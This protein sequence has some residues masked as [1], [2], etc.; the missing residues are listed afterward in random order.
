MKRGIAASTTLATRA[1][2]GVRA[3]VAACVCGLSLFPACRA[4]A[5]TARPAELAALP[6]AISAPVAAAAGFALRV[7]GR[8]KDAIAAWRACAVLAE[9]ADELPLRLRCLGDAGL[10]ASF[11]GQHALAAALQRE[12]LDLAR[13]H[14]PAEE[15]G[16][17]LTLAMLARRA[18]DL[19]AAEVG[20]R[21]VV[22]LAARHHDALAQAQALSGL[23]VVRKNLGDY[24]EA[25][26]AETASLALRLSVGPNAKLHISYINLA[27][28]YEQLE[29]LDRARDYQARAL[30][31]STDSP[32]PLDRAGAQVSMA[33]LLNDSGAVYA[34]T[35]YALA[36][37]AYEQHRRLGNRPGMLDARFHRGRAQ[38]LMGHLD[39]AQA[40]LEPLLAEAEALGQRASK[41]HVLFRLAEV[42]Q[43]RGDERLALDLA[44]RALA[45]YVEVDNPH[46]QAKTHALLQSIYA[47]QGDTVEA[48]QHEVARL[49]LRERLLGVN[50]MRR[51]GALFDATR[52]HADSDRIRLLERDNQMVEALNE[53][54]AYQRGIWALVAL[55]LGLVLVLVAWRY[56]LSVVRNHLFAEREETGERERARL[57]EAN[58]QLYTSATT[59]PLTGLANRSHGLEWLRRAIGSAGD[60]GTVAI[61]LV[62]VDHFKRINDT[63]GHLAGD[64][65]LCEVA[66]TLVR[67]L[68]D[69]VVVARF[70][71]EEFL[72][73]FDGEPACDVARRLERARA[74]MAAIGDASGVEVTVSIG[75]CVRRG[76]AAPVDV[77]LAAADAA[78]YRAKAM[79]RNRV[80]GHARPVAP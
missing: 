62:D 50:A 17:S 45:T 37:D 27:A 33:G 14:V 47:A 40:E 3:V 28:L 21:G 22:R 18:G 49:R 42:A 75:W 16:A 44:Q 65:V 73:V 25:L 64:A 36:Q 35:A 79:G 58:A 8:P 51:V 72:A 24:Y 34:P 13:D 30:A 55:S 12:R 5:A 43:A 67:T 41:G 52:A 20:F 6:P 69:A 10:A 71:G 63:Y 59:D 61:A 70:G 32:D 57:A 23:A 80:E 76:H 53:R 31:A 11:A 1:P 48:M 77:L 29:D 54:D 39:A 46:R 15:I 56:R 68:A 74:A 78:M 19:A 4:D 38:L 7:A 26:E 9:R 66:A 2:R 60:D